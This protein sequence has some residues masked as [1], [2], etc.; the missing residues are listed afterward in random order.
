[1][2]RALF[3]S[4]VA[5]ICACGSSGSNGNGGTGGNGGGGGTG[6]G[7][8]SST[9]MSASAGNDAGMTLPPDM[10]PAYGC[11]AL[12][13]C[14]DACTDQTS[15]TLCI[16]SATSN[17]RTLYSAVSRC[18]RRLCFPHPD[19]GAAPCTNGGGTPSTECNQCQDDSLKMTGSCGSD[20]TYCGQCYAAYSACL[21]DKP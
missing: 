11:N 3:A 18:V 13:T 21:A 15:C 20:T 5:L 1:M 16:Q 12:N 14:L 2:K 8:G 19:G 10:L 17:A 7:A 4:V 9:D 6:G